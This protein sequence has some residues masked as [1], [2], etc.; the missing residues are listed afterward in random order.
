MF[1][2]YSVTCW[3]LAIELIESFVYSVKGKYTCSKVYMVGELLVTWFSR[4]LTCAKII[5]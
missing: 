1:S 4:L 2:L 3:K 5:M